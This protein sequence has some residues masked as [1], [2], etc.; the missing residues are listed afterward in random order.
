[1]RL[2]APELASC[3]EGILPATMATVAADGTP[4][5][6]HVS[7]VTLVDAET[8]ALTHQFFRKT[9][10]NLGQGGRACLLLSRAEDYGQYRLHVRHLGSQTSGGLFEE[11]RARLAAIAA[12]SGMEGV[13][14]LA[15]VELFHVDEV[16]PVP[17]ALRP[18]P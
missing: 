18:V 10:E 13:F 1:M 8:I 16:E 5:V 11:T 2:D 4:N 12:M 17:A 14:T 3:F 15:S 6:I 7:K 9:M